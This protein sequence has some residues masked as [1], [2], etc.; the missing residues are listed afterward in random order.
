MLS[1]HGWEGEV[2]ALALTADASWELWA[3]REWP[4]DEAVLIFFRK[5]TVG[6]LSEK[7]VKKNLF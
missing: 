7:K 2:P 1:A 3:V 4:E 5:H 6:L